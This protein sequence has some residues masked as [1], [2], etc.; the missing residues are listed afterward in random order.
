MY[1][2]HLA[3]L[4]ADYLPDTC[5]WS[6]T[7]VTYYDCNYFIYHLSVGPPAVSV[8]CRCVACSTV[9]P[10]RTWEPVASHCVASSAIWF[11]SSHLQHDGT[12]ILLRCHLQVVWS[13]S[14]QIPRDFSCTDLGPNT[15]RS[16]LDMSDAEVER[17]TKHHF[18]DGRW[19]TR[20]EDSEFQLSCHWHAQLTCEWDALRVA[21]KI[22]SSPHQT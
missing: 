17:V 2:W 10:C 16:W 18:A 19:S 21:A 3:K 6:V 7:S 9:P 22:D 5:I 20:R 8:R 4:P 11:G 12:E 14:S 13:Q 1:L 15:P